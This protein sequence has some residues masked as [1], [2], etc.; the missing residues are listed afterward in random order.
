MNECS[1]YGQGCKLISDYRGKNINNLSL[2]ELS[3]AGA[4]TGRNYRSFFLC[5]LKLLQIF[6]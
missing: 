1:G 2:S 5:T 4:Y 3:L 6:L